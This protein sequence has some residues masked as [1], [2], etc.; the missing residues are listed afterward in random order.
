MGLY[1]TGFKNHNM[2]QSMASISGVLDIREHKNQ[3]KIKNL[4]GE[5]TPMAEKTDKKSQ[6]PAKDENIKQENSSHSQK[7]INEEE[8]EKQAE[9]R[10]LWDSNAVYALIGSK[11]PA[12]S[13]RQII[14]VTGDKDT[15][16]LEENRKAKELLYKRGFKFDYREE[17]GVHDW[18]FWKIHIPATLEK[19]ADYLN[20]LK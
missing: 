7:P 8:I 2:F 17:Q 1:L 16:V 12:T 18:N 14:I 11:W 20:S 15:L 5:L 9:T 6:M 4:L 13:P 10:K 3:W 19:Q